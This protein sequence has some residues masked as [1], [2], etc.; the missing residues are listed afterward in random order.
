MMFNADDRILVFPVDRESLP[1]I[2]GTASYPNICIHRL[3]APES[4]GH[5]GESFMCADGMVEIHHDYENGLTD[6]S[7]VWIVDSWNEL[8][9][10]KF[11][12]PAIRLAYG[13]SKRVVCSRRLSALEKALLSDIELDYVDYS[14]FTPTI[15]QDDRVQEIRTPVIFILSNTELCN[16]FYIETAL[17]EELRNR[18]YESLLISSQK[19]CIVFGQYS[20]PHFMF[21]NEFSENK[22]V[23][24]FN[25]YIRHLEVKHNPEI[26]II[27]VPGVAMPYSH[28]YSIDFG[29]TAY[30]MSEAVKP[31]F[32]VL[33]SPCMPYDTDYFKSVEESLQGR[34]GISVDVHS[35]SP[36]ALDMTESS[37]EKQLGYLSVDDAYIQETVDRIGYNKL[38][39]LNRKQEM[40]HV[41]DRIIDKLSGG[42]STYIT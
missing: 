40:T 30:E 33:S 17:C 28:Q 13:N 9:F 31:D 42:V 14:A 10:C 23:I 22:K 34:L 35:L 24:A 38:L 16:Q 8:D 3:I 19:E 2:K 12:E 39:N 11:I 4:W 18:S 29:I 26:F 15:G 41:V 5:D 7:A 32:T 25:K 36:Y 37:I 6:C 27:G 20:I 1:V 21:G